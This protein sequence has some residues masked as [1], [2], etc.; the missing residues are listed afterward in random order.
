MG[1]D[2]FVI[3]RSPDLL[4]RLFSPAVMQLNHYAEKKKQGVCQE[5]G[6]AKTI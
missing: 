6:L 3:G 2:L 5:I 1:N 4:F